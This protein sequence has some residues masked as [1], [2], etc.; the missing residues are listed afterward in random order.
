[1]LPT[2]PVRDMNGHTIWR[3]RVAANELTCTR[4]GE[5]TADLYCLRRDEDDHADGDY[6]LVPTM[7]YLHA[8]EVELI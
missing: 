1:M 2:E 8:E 3:V 4:C 7:S 6:T 5:T